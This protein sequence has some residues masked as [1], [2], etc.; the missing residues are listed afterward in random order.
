MPGVVG[1]LSSLKVLML[2]HNGLAKLPNAIGELVKLERLAVEHNDLTVLPPTMVNLTSLTFLD[3]SHNNLRILPYKIGELGSLEELHADNNQLYSL[4]QSIGMCTSLHTLALSNNFI[5]VV[6]LSIQYLSSLT[7]LS[8]KNNAI[9]VLPPAMSQNELLVNF[10][11][12]NNPILDPPKLVLEKGFDA[13]MLYLKKM[14]DVTFTGHLDLRDLQLPDLPAD[15]LGAMGGAGDEGSS[16]ATTE[17]RPPSARKGTAPAVKLGV[18]IR[19]GLLPTSQPRASNPIHCI[20]WTQSR[21]N[22]SSARWHDFSHFSH[23]FI[24]LPIDLIAPRELSLTGNRLEYL[25]PFVGEL[26]AL[27]DIHIDD[28]IKEPPPHILGEGLQVIQLY[29]RKLGTSR[30][31]SFLDLSGMMLDTVELSY[32]KLEELVNAVNLGHNKLTSIPEEIFKYR[33]LTWLDMRNNRIEEIPEAIGNLTEIRHMDMRNNQISVA[34][35]HIFQHNSL[36][37]MS[38]QN[39]PVTRLGGS[40]QGADARMFL[41][42]L[43]AD[44]LDAEEDGTDD[45]PELPTEEEFQELDRAAQQE[46]LLDVGSLQHLL[47]KDCSLISIPQIIGTALT[48]LDLGR[49]RLMEGCIEQ[50]AALP[51]LRIL[52]LPGNRLRSIPEEIEDLAS[53][54]ILDLSS[55]HLTVIPPEVTLPL[56]LLPASVLNSFPTNITSLFCSVARPKAGLIA[57]HSPTRS[58]CPHWQTSALLFASADDLAP[59]SE[60]VSKLTKLSFLS[61]RFNDI[62]VLPGALFKLTQIQQ[63]QLSSNRIEAIPV[64]VGDLLGLRELLVDNNQIMSL[65]LELGKLTRL[66]ELNVEGNPGNLLPEGFAEKGMKAVME[67]FAWNCYYPL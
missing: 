38:L 40:S 19:F 24:N 54:V 60:Q 32:Y 37:Y 52:R 62:S 29:L 66:E 35:P 22:H 2:D 34:P 25:P 7:H 16:S 58:L 13:V 44:N 9:K 11:F 28:T 43:Q 33:S 20:S 64:F 23:S 63:L 67:F 36:L 21:W 46:E 41:A 27:R 30:H 45:Y 12:A 6:P 39:N 53:L 5:S 47:F 15:L 4:P 8:V 57:A 56:P 26:S 42:Q 50:I 18:P 17:A 10:D 3:A 48:Q 59:P 65:P 49:N 55:N 31:T 14:F 61:L 51:R 1:T